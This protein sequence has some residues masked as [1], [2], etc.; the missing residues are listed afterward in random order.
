M[1]ARKEFIDRKSSSMIFDPQIGC[2]KDGRGR[3]LIR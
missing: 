1:P 2:V 3:G